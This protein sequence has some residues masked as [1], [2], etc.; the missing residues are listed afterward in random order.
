MSY[1]VLIVDDEPLARAGLGAL[2]RRDPAVARVTEAGSAAEAWPVIE[3]DRPDLLFLDVQMPGRSGLELAERLPRVGGPV[4]VFVTAFERYALRAFDLHA[5]DYLLKPYSDERFHEALE[6]AKQR[7][8]L[9]RLGELDDR[10]ASVLAELRRGD[11]EAPLPKAP[12]ASADSA[13]AVFRT[14]G[15]IHVAAVREIR[16]V[17]AQ[18]DYLRIHGAG[19][20]VL[21]RETMRAF[22]ERFPGGP[23]V[24][25]HKSSIVNVAWVARV[26]HLAAGDYEAE[27]RDGTRVRVSRLHR[28]DLLRALG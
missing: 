6:R 2:L 4:T 27:L 16:W 9:G 12:A 22:L 15:E 25:V 7:L 1:S 3:R 18:G 23:F 10:L 14:G 21:V 8:R 13:T 26:E 11:R 5:V 28:E 17:E 19:P 24:R 20:A